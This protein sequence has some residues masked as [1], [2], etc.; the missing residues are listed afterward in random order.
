MERNYI[1]EEIPEP[2]EREIINTDLVD[3]YEDNYG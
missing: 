2:E 1:G 3:N